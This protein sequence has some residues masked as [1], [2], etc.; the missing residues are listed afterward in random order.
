MI[1]QNTCIPHR[2]NPRLVTLCSSLRHDE[3]RNK[4]KSIVGSNDKYTHYFVKQ[5]QHKHTL[6]TRYAEIDIQWLLLKIS[7][8]IAR[9]W[10]EV[11]KVNVL[12]LSRCEELTELHLG[13]F[14]ISNLTMYPNRLVCEKIQKSNSVIL[15]E[16][17]M[18]T[19]FISYNM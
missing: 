8:Q 9:G 13:S 11:N 15:H 4:A 5:I 18:C 17:T 6:Y 19:V 2:R 12:N 1:P 10:N 14:N 7:K 16:D 3:E